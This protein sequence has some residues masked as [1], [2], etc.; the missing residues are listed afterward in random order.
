MRKKMT[1]AQ[2]GTPNIQRTRYCWKCS[3]D[4]GYRPGIVMRVFG[5]LLA[6]GFLFIVG[7]RI[8]TEWI[9]HFGHLPAQEEHPQS[10]WG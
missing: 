5:I 2:C 6:L 3:R 8:K 10:P 7:Y 4:T 9:D 1:C